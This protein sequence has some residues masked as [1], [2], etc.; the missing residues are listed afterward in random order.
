MLRPMSMSRLQAALLVGCFTAALCAACTS[1][2]ADSRATGTTLVDP[3]AKSL[4]S[5]EV[6]APGPAQAPRKPG[7][8]VVL[9]HCGVQNIMYEGIE[10]EVEDIP[11]DGT[12]APDTFTGFG[13]FDRR[14]ESLLFTDDLGATLTFVRWDGTPNPYNCA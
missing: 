6:P 5:G 2:A 12:N 13:S 14:G 11:F 8:S 3:S 1:Q 10:W 4:R 7:Q 9:L